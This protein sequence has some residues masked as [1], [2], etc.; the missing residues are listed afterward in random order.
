M[1]KIKIK[2]YLA[3]P[4]FNEAEKKQRMYEEKELKRRLKNLHL[5][6]VEF[7]VY[8]P[9][10]TPFNADKTN[11]LPSCETIYINDL[12]E[13]ESSHFVLVD[14]TNFD[15]GTMCEL[16]IALTRGIPVI[17]VC[18]DIRLAGANKYELPPYGLNHFV[19]GGI[20]GQKH[21]YVRKKLVYSADEGIKET[22]EYMKEIWGTH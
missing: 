4:L 9:L 8:N 17:A 2:I 22:V 21:R 3:G 7:V 10:T 15:P 20:L 12:K 5:S 13:L 6:N 1:E 18:S 11:T 14:I 19:L 16:G